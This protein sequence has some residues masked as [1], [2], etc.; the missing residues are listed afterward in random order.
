MV[1]QGAEVMKPKVYLS[2]IAIVSDE[3]AWAKI[4][5]S[6]EDY[7][8]EEFG[9]LGVKPHITHLKQDPGCVY[10]VVTVASPK[11][12]LEGDLNTVLWK[13][14]LEGAIESKT[15]S[16]LD[17]LIVKR[18]AEFGCGVAPCHAGD[19]F[20]RKRGRIMSKGR[21]FKLLRAE[22]L[23]MDYVDSAERLDLCI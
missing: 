1:R 8:A 13:I 21:L 11:Y 4:H 18:F 15:G 3:L 7:L 6:H 14:Y 12:E 9:L 16:A 17:A 19:N 20:S 10:S 2:R 5:L 23:R 22:M